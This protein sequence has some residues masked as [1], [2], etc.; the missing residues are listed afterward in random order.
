VP[1]IVIGLAVLI[2]AWFVMARPQALTKAPAETV[3]PVAVINVTPVD[4]QPEILAYGE[5]RASRE[6]EIRAM[7]AGRLVSLN[8]QFQDGNLLAAGAE[9]A[10][11]DPVDDENRLAEQRAELARAGALLAEHERELQWENQLHKNAERQLELAERG[12][13]RNAE[14][15]RSGRES[16]KARDD[17]EVAVANAEQ[18]V[19]QRSQT[20]G[21]LRARVAQQQAAY[22]KAQAVTAIAERELARTQVIAP[23]AGYVTDV[24]LAL[25]KLVAV[26]EPL[27]RLLSADELEVRFE[28]PE[29]DF[30]RLLQTVDDN[31]GGASAALIG[32]EI[33]V[34]W[35]LGDSER[36]F[37]AHLARTGAEI[38]PTL[39]G[40]KLIASVDGAAVKYGLRAGAFVEVRVPDKHYRGVYRLPARAVSSDGQIYVL[41][42]GRLLPLD[43]K[44]E[45]ELDGEVLLRAALVGG[46]AVVARLF[47]GIG[48]GMRARPL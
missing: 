12:F 42:E 39:G 7:V 3:W 27:G 10:T 28:L 2:A 22:E 15:Q 29:A 13:E 47:A 19:L 4:V 48:P 5:I 16:K 33:G 38:D 21:R 30:A 37:S 1:L 6:A 32:R 45:R 36:H 24:K 46:D 43:V 14:L 17:S 25:G 44:I 31:T 11:I 20:M 40:I 8:A 18:N 41:R 23:F 35:R 9:L 34:V 26:G